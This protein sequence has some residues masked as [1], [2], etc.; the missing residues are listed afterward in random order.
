[1][2]LGL[3][4]WFSKLIRHFF[5]SI[6]R[7]VFG[8]IPTIY[9][10]LISIA[11][12]SVLSQADIIG[13]AERIYDLLAIFMSFK[14][15]FS[16]IMYVVNPDDFSDKSKGVGKLTTNIIISLGLLILTPYIFRLAYQTQTIILEDN[17]LVN[18]V[19][20]KK[21]KK[22]FLNSAGD[23]I[24]FTMMLPFFSPNVSINELQECINL[25]KATVDTSGENISIINE[26]CFGLK[27]GTY[28][29]MNDATS[30]KALTGKNF[31]LQDLQN[32]AAGIEHKNL[33]LMF[34][35]GIA[36]ATDNSNEK[37]IID[38]RYI[39]STAL[40]IVVLLILVTFCMDVALRSVKLAFLQLIAPIPIL[41]YVDPK[42]GK[43]GLFK[44][45][46]QMCF[47]TFLSLF[48][49]LLALY[50][51]VYIISLIDRMVDIID[52]SYVTN[53][54]IK[55][56]IIIG[57]L[58]FVKQLPK[59]L[60]GL[61]IKLDGDGKFFLNPL[62]KFQDQA[63][64][65]NNILG[66]GA[67][68]LAG[69]AAFGTNLIARK[70]NVF[71]ATA[72]ALSATGR[73]LVGAAKGEKFGKNFSNSYSGA[74]KART[75]RADRKELGISALDVAKENIKTAMHI[76]N[77]SQK[78]KVRLDHLSEY[79]KAGTA[80]KT[81]AEG[82]VDKKASMISINGENLGALRDSYEILKNTQITRGDGESL[83]AYQARVSEH[84]QLAAKANAKYF[85]ARKKAVNA[86]VDNASKL[87][88]GDFT[89]TE[90]DSEGRVVLDSDGNPVTYTVSGF[91]EAFTGAAA[92][93]EIVASNVENMKQ[94]DDDYHMGQPVDSTDIGATI[95]RAENESTRIQSSKEYRQ[96]E[97]IARQAQKEKSSK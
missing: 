46:Y 57:T 62:K 11:R 27:S 75:D 55:I 9:D 47:K 95:Q 18:L 36:K 12:T 19:F 61:G 74:M 1:M 93:D 8:F 28:E 88:T 72:G 7:V 31:S 39:F 22:K 15:I 76:P 5:F 30:L 6:D 65:A 43:D 73:G 80:A 20:G 96:S 21:D 34:R 90:R 85:A 97:L 23:E 70:G 82:E 51:G 86:Y 68:G 67:A 94:L 38:Y 40:G 25:T 78:Y 66:A 92:H 56:F 89:Y 33:P 32:Y 58:M 81:R 48:L 54:W 45:W 35:V 84:A 50:F 77:E 83:E 24:A 3:D 79:T 64:G 59:I 71:S 42:S 91:D 41:S 29:E 16:L 17:T 44:K 52:G 4:M 13:M 10:L 60:E 14:V 87:D 26:K 69:A 37:F 53:M 49:R 63:Y 2:F